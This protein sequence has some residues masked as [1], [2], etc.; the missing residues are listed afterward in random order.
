MAIARRADRG[1][2]GVA[3]R[4]ADGPAIRGTDGF[5]LVSSL[6]RGVD[7]FRVASL[8]YAVVVFATRYEVYREPVGAAAVLL[9]MAVWTAVVWWWP[10]RP[11]WLVVVDMGL[12]FAAVLATR[13]VDD[14]VRVGEGASTLPLTW[15]AAAVLAWA[16]W[17]GWVAGVAGALVIGAA[18]VLV[19]DPVNQGTV[20]NIVLLLLA[21]AVV[22]YSADLYRRSQA[23]LA[24]ALRLEAVTRERERLARDIH[25]SVLQ[26]LAFVQRRGAEIG[27]ESSDLGRLAGEQEERLRTLVSSRVVPTATGDV[28]LRRLLSRHVRASTSPRPPSRCRCPTRGPVTWQRPW[29]PPSTTSGGTPAPAPRRGCWSRTPATRSPSR[30]GTTAWASR[31]AGSSRQ[32]ATAGSAWRRPCGA[33]WVTT[34]G[35]RPW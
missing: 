25:D 23:S 30:C 32:S 17:R 1:T 20:H 14:P 6:W 13:F 16:I 3:S 24:Q 5:G 21:G 10:S 7:V 29:E 12:S 15:P 18:D 28:D 34:A 35:R 11:T 4:G 2:A 19:V 26:V 27:G 31:P 33:G 22:G 9:A 8:V